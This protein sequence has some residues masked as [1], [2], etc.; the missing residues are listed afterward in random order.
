[1]AIRP[2]R[3]NIS[4]YCLL[5]VL[6]MGLISCGKKE[7]PQQ[8]TDDVKLIKLMTVEASLGS[9]RREFPGKTQATQ[10]ADL[11][12]RINGPL[13]ELPVQEGQYVEQGELLA[14]IDPRDYETIVKQVS[15]SL[16]AARSQLQ[17]MQAG[18][19]PEE[20]ERL[21]ADVAAREAQLE[22]VKTRYD[23]YRKLYE[24]EVISKQQLD[25]VRAEYNVA[26]QSLE[27][28]KQAMTQGQ[29]GAR[30][31]DVD[32][33][34][35]TISGLEAQ[36][37]EAQNALADTELRAPFSGI[38]ARKY[39]EN[40]EFVQAKQ[41]IL[42]FQDPKRIEIA[43]DVPENEL[44]RAGESVANVRSVI[45]T[46]MQITA[47]FPAYPGREFPV[48]LKSFETEADPTTQTF[49]VTFVM[50][51]PGEPPIVPGMNAVIRAK[52]S[53]DSGEPVTEFYVPLNA[54]F[55]D[56]AGNQNVWVVDPSTQQVQR[57]QIVADEMSGDSIRVTDGLQ[58]GEVI[59]VSAVNS[60]RE[61]MKVKQ[62]PDL[63]KL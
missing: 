53:A 1:M 52:R 46:L 49:R 42:S 16:Q 19:R 3:N 20:M 41:N 33:Q 27:S 38:V 5:L 17:A 44:A 62:M 25:S 47:I 10:I 56:T 59:A 15:A 36:L 51:Q 58:S 29:T 8:K 26:V 40:H 13:V 39:V 18:A 22:E 55:A 31:E 57:R 35:A 6:A 45:G 2:W 37:K 4:L 23:R 11:A 14:K 48:E 60:L 63:E 24:E 21:R 43:I 12:F 61:G 7:A 50:D 54:V 28:S 9:G 34:R 30:V 32:A